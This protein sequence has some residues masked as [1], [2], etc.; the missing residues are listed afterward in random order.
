MLDRTSLC[1][2][3]LGCKGLYQKTLYDFGRTYFTTLQTD[4]SLNDLERLWSISQTEHLKQHVQTLHI[5]EQQRTHGEEGLWHRM[6]G[7][8][9]IAYVDTRLSL[10]GG[11][12]RDILQNLTACRSFRFHSFGGTE[13]HYKSRCLMPSD[14][15]HIILAI[16]GETGL[17]IK[18]FHIDF[19]SRGSVDA[20]RLQIQSYRQPKFIVAWENLEELRLEHCLTADTLEWSRDLIIRTTHLKK[21]ALHL[22]YDE[23]TAFLGSI[24]S[25]MESFKG[26]QEIEFGC[27]HT[28]GEILSTL[29]LHC[30]SSLRKLSF[31]HVY[32]NYGTW[33]QILTELRSFE[34]LEYIAVEWPREFENEKTIRL[35]FPALDANQVVPG[36]GGQKFTLKCKKWRGKKRVWGARYQGRVAMDK[37]LEILAESAEDTK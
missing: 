36:T 26:L 30:R 28:T 1:N 16:F 29:L 37:A 2:V 24:I 21:L 20:K 11:M 33:V 15:I 8:E 10:G 3:R 18:S 22:N 31:W 14:A 6:G 32:I 27:I 12:L 17:P 4:L 5:K 23:T 13:E 9:L 7:N 19:Q 35:Q 34:S 25:S